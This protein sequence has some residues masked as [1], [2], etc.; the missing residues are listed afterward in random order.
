MK[1]LTGISREAKARL[2]AA[3]WSL[4]LA[5]CV[6]MASAQTQSAQVQ[7]ADLPSAPM[8][9]NLVKLPGGVMVE[10]ATP[11]ALPLSLDD[12]IARGQKR[13]L[14][15]LLVIQNERVVR[16]RGWVCPRGRSTRSSR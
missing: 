2:W 16:G 4:A 7:S 5:S 10:Q 12:A 9:N 6:P 11:G 3:V 13:N 1:A 8:P 15:M 14:Q